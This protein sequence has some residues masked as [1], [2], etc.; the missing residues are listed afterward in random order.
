VKYKPPTEIVWLADFFEAS[1]FKR[2]DNPSKTG[3]YF[4]FKCDEE[5]ILKQKEIMQEFP[6]KL[7]MMTK[8]RMVVG[9]VEAKQ[10]RKSYSRLV[11]TVNKEPDPIEG[12]LKLV[13][14]MN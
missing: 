12:E 5:S 14:V 2:Y 9:S 6:N 13:S 4:L 11:Y 7:A 10:K 3:L 8:L 1:Y